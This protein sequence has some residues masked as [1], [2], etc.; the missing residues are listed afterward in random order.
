[1]DVIRKILARLDGMVARAVI[2]RVND[3]L[4]TQ[5]LQLTVLDDDDVADNVEH[6]QPYGVSFTPPEGAECIALAVAGARD[7]TIAICAN[8]PGKRPTGGAA[9]TGGLYTEGQWRVFIDADG[10]VHVGAEAGESEIARADYVD[11]RVSAIQAKL[12]A[13]IGLYNSH[14]HPVSGSAADP[15]TMSVP[16]PLGAQAT[17]ASTTSK[18]T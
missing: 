14:T 3:A 2:S 13:F 15:T 10:V 12:D 9:K 5:R 8:A 4:K 6:M 17:V 11:A 1:M 16:A 7:H 18:T